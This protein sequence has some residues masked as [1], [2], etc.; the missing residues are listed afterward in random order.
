MKTNSIEAYASNNDLESESGAQSDFDVLSISSDITPT[1]PTE[2]EAQSEEVKLDGRFAFQKGDD[3]SE[4]IIGENGVL[5]LKDVSV[6]EFLVLLNAIYPPV[7]EITKENV[8]ILLKVSYRFGVEHLIMKCERYLMSEEGQQFFDPLQMLEF[9]TVYKMAALQTDTLLK[10]RTANDVRK[11]LDDPRMEQ[12]PKE[13]RSVLLETLL[14]RFKSDS[15]IQKESKR[16]QLCP[17]VISYDFI[18]IPAE[19]SV[20]TST[21]TTDSSAEL[22]EGQTSAE[23]AE[24]ASLREELRKQEALRMNLEMSLKCARDFI[25][26]TERRVAAAGEATTSA[27]G[28]PA[29]LRLEEKVADVKV[30]FRVFQL[31]HYPTLSE[32]TES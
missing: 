31:Y 21:K 13:V 20:S 5:I 16:Q 10:L 12:T 17:N 15:I 30:R 1:N 32:S 14:Q 9:S 26:D 8:L 3:A 19:A 11:L 28:S 27:E 4:F 2:E 6:K 25:Q 7:A 23:S 29:V 18:L 22:N 24:V